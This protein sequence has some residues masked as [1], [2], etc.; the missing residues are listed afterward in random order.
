MAVKCGVKI[1]QDKKILRKSIKEIERDKY[2]DENEKKRRIGIIKNIIEEK[3]IKKR[4]SKLYDMI[5]DYL[6]DEFIH[7][8]VCGFEN[9]LCS[10]RK[11]MMEKGIKKDTYLNGC[12]HSYKEGKDCQYLKNGRCSIKNIACKTFTCPYLKLKGK[13]Y[14]INKIYFAKYFFNYR[15][16][17]YMQNT[18]FVDK[19]V[20]LKGILER[21]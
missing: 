11:Y 20:V 12:C 21:K 3:N 16:K 14:S 10:R 5:C 19:N 18:Y 4:Y 9:N 13:R 15:Q 6:D 2:I 8:N 7:K 17:F 1:M